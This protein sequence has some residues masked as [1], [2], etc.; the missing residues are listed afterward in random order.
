MKG[1]G[2]QSLNRFRGLEARIQ[3]LEVKG[4]DVKSQCF[5]VSCLDRMLCVF[6]A[7]M[8]RRPYCRCRNLLPPDVPYI[9]Y[10]DDPKP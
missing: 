1:L 2:L 4:L 6:F 5:G 10:V 9:P 3:I 8:R 7:G